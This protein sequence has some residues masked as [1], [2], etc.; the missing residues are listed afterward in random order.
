[1]VGKVGG[2]MTLAV[3]DMIGF[4]ILVAIM[5]GLTFGED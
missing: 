3:I 1:M 2:S 4:A 5:F